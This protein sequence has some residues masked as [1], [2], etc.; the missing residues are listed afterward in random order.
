WGDLLGGKPVLLDFIDKFGVQSTT[1][2]FE[3]STINSQN[4]YEK[5][6][7]YD[8]LTFNESYKFI[9][10]VT[11]SVEIFQKDDNGKRLP[12]FGNRQYESVSLIGESQNIV[13]VDTTKTGKAM[14]TF[15]NPVFV[16]NQL[17]TFG[18]EA[19]EQYPFYEKVVNGVPVIKQIGGK[20]VLDNVPTTDGF[21]SIL[22]K[23]RN[24]SS[25]PDTFSLN[26]KGVAEYQFTAGDPSLATQGIKGFSSSIRFGTATNINW[27][28]LGDPQLNVYVMG[29]KLAGTGFVTAG[30]DRLLMVLRDPP[31]SKSFSY[32]EQGSTITNSTTYG[33]GVD[34]V[35]DLELTQKLGTEL[36][37]FC[38][39]GVGVVNS[40]VATT[41]ASIGIH[42]EENYSN[43][44]TKE[45]STTLTTKFQTSDDPLF[46]GPVA[47]V[48]VGYSTNITY[49]QS[50]N[51]TIIKRANLKASDI[52]LYQ[53]SASSNYVV[54]QRP[55]INI[56]ETF[57]T[58]FA[59]P[60]Q[61][62][63]RVLI[64]SLIDIRN[65]ALLPVGTSLTAAQTLANTQKSAVY[66]SK[67]QNSDPNFVKSNNDTIAFGPTAKNDPVGNGKSYTIL[68]P[69]SSL[70]RSDTIMVLNQYVADWE[71]R[72]ADNEKA[73]LESS[74][75]QNY[76]F[77]AG[78]PIEYSTTTSI[79]QS[80]EH[81]FNFIL[82]GSA[83]NTSEVSLNGI[84]MDFK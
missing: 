19:F 11:P 21:V 83:S 27:N 46:V 20:N 67:L 34:Q 8:S 48:F 55:G 53:A 30:P 64:P 68:Y 17:Y 71:K 72:M 10:R 78:S 33:G 39:F 26:D 1:R 28:W 12:Y 32:A 14:Y 43:S 40:A 37:P 25:D 23:I 13:V 57:G 38:G 3:D 24:G 29:G 56:G 18:I 58:L 65:I 76:S 6:S 4:V 59:Y 81:N 2:H 36:V 66:V 69:A 54:I 79:T 62:I 16:Q 44:S 42:H 77:H 50:N 31:G 61:H 82:S 52:M 75:I 51:I 7:Y 5:T 74:L 41:G 9:K 35:G 84:G 70:Y 73:K 22:N 45:S 60:Q 47:D 15:G 80:K 63:E 49:G